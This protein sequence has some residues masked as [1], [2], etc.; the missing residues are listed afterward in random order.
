MEKSKKLLQK[1]MGENKLLIEENEML[2]KNN[3]GLSSINETLVRSQRQYEEKWRKIF[4][5]L[6]FYKEFYHKYL[7]LTLSNVAN[8]SQD[9]QTLEKY[10]EQHSNFELLIR[11]PEKL[12]NEKRRKEQEPGTLVNVSILDLNDD[13]I[14]E[15]N[16]LDLLFQNNEKENFKQYLLNL[17]KDVNHLCKKTLIHSRNELDEE[18]LNLPIVKF[19]KSLSNPIDYRT[20]IQRNLLENLK[21][22][23]PVTVCEKKVMKMKL[24][25]NNF[26]I[27]MKSP[28]FGSNI[29]NKGEEKDIVEDFALESPGQI[30]YHTNY[31]EEEMVEENGIKE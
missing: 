5:A 24:N 17:A 29:N 14:K 10:K 21:K 2:I 22:Q 19:K 27:P 15:E 20:E 26:N 23:M 25:V 7:E 12:I 28:A 6:Q 31:E 11:D 18:N 1:E 4:H 9:F 16:K 8:K 30:I 3:R 13:H